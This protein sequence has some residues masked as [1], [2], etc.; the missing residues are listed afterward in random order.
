MTPTK[1][2][3]DGKE[4]NLPPSVRIATSELRINEERLNIA[5]YENMLLSESDEDVRFIIYE[6]IYGCVVRASM[7]K[8]GIEEL[9][10]HI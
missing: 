6:K 7:E 4:Y 5:A 1:F 2:N 9:K 3:Y 8:A 10:K